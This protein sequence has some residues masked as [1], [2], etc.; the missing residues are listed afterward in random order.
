MSERAKFSLF[1]YGFRPFF[2]AA[3][4]FALLGIA[5]WLW[6]YALGANPLPGQPP[7]FWHA[8]EML[9]GFVGAAIAGF[10]L[11]AV[12]SWTGARGFAGLPLVLV[13]IVWLAGRLAFAGAARVPFVLLAIC[14]LAFLPALIALVA[15]PLIRERNRNTKLLFVLAALWLTDAAFLYAVLRG[16][17]VLARHM[18]LI[19]IDIILV[20]VTVIGGRIV[21]AFTASGLRN[22]GVVADI[23][24][25]RWA[26]GLAI[27][28]M[29]AVVLVDLVAPWGAIA[30]GVAALAALGHAWRLAGWRSLKT[31][32]EPLV[33]CLHLAYVW[34]P[35]GLALK[36]VHLMTGAAWAAYWLHALTIGTA[37]A[38]I[39]SVMTRAALGHTGRPLRAAA[40]IAAA[41]AL[42]ALAALVRVFAPA[43][44]TVDYRAVVMIAGALWI[45]AFALFVIVYTPILMR[46]RVDG[47][48]G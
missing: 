15:P 48:P 38:M 3:G 46:P 45:A 10:L 24:G 29:L 14:E 44:L 36:A 39:L 26:D 30:G 42:L 40:P 2:W 21:P 1:A 28:A 22:R 18:L 20:L 13:S 16:H 9:Y 17:A 7:Q 31:L 25:S 12:P 5:A 11:T 43:V 6:I 4:V 32:G 8:H 23:R 47:K 27:G 33:W 34:L 37:A 35:V 41:Y 19:G